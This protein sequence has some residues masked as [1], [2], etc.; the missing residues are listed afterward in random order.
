MRRCRSCAG[1]KLS[2]RCK[3]GSEP[4]SEN[5]P[6]ST[7]RSPLSWRTLLLAVGD[8]GDESAELDVLD[9]DSPEKVGASRAGFVTSSDEVD[10]DFSTTTRGRLVTASD[11]AGSAPSACARRPNLIAAVPPSFDG[12]RRCA[13]RADALSYVCSVVG[14]DAAE[15][16]AV[17]PLVRA[18]EAPKMATENLRWHLQE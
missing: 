17:I 6:D 9:V 14:C 15:L 18:N 12:T 8:T 13:A 16:R 2:E 5:S 11:F 1:F 3:P 4:P 7:S 10:S